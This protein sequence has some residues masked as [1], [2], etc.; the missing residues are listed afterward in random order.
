MNNSFTTLVEEA[1]AVLILLPRG[2]YFDQVAAALGLY[3]SLKQEYEEKEISVLSPSPMLVE[4][5][6]LVGIDKIASQ[7]GNN[8]LKIR[9]V[10]YSIDAIGKVS[11]DEVP[12]AKKVEFLVVPKKGYGPPRENQIEISYSGVSADVVILIGG[13]NEGHFPLLS[14]ES[15]EEAKFLHIGAQDL[16]AR[17]DRGILSY[18]KAASSVSEVVADLLKSNGVTIVSEAASNLLMGL[19]EGS[20][21]FSGRNV[22]ADTFSTAALLMSQ[23]GKLRE[24]EASPDRFPAGSMPARLM[25]ARGRALKPSSN[26]APPHPAIASFEAE[27]EGTAETLPPKDWLKKPKVFKGASGN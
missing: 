11:Y 3:L 6:R 24:A 14:D 19:Y 15:F 8:N 16:S 27:E 26:D 18:A 9:F 22:T 5:N 12:G 4:F 10:D 20:K 25:A 7:A 17:A 1:G 23:G 2:P 21:N 13:A